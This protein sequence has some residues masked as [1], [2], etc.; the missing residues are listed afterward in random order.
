MSRALGFAVYIFACD[1]SVKEASGQQVLCASVG[2]PGLMQG[3]RTDPWVYENGSPECALFISLSA[4]HFRFLSCI[5]WHFFFFSF[6]FI[7][8]NPFSRGTVYWY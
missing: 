1:F 4:V 5:V 8:L 7:S 3:L 6:Q 2:C